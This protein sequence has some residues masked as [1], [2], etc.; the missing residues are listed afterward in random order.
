MSEETKKVLKPSQMYIVAIL[1]AFAGG[2][3][4]AY[5]YFQR[6][7]VFANAQTGNIIKLS[8]ALA[9]AEF[10]KIP[11]Y[12]IPILAFI[13]G[14]FVTLAIHTYF[15]KRK[16]THIR[17]TILLIEMVLCVVVAFVPNGENYNIVANTLVSFICAMQM[18]CF[19][20]FEGLILA[21]TVGTGNLR[22]C[23]EYSYRVIIRHEPEKLRS[24]LLTLGA[25]LCFML[26]VV[27]G[28][29]MSE[30]GGQ[31]AVLFTLLP[32]GGSLAWIRYKQVQNRKL[33]VEYEA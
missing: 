23:V 30:I 15:H 5:T 9:Q 3:F 8:I 10:D 4:D 6:G 20:K 13:G 14:T 28:V 33:G 25:L 11:V 31:Y 16:I 32:L 17:K 29:W 24:A 21:T 18:Q 2:F 1:L 26:G 22:K 12:L 27:V 19:Q 7:G